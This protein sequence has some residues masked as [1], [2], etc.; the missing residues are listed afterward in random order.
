[1]S[2]SSDLNVLNVPQ[3]QYISLTCLSSSVSF[4]RVQPLDLTCVQSCVSRLWTMWG[5]GK[6]DWNVWRNQ[7][8]VCR[9]LCQSVLKVGVYL[10]LAFRCDDCIYSAL[11]ANV[12]RCSVITCPETCLSNVANIIRKSIENILRYDCQIDYY[13]GWAGLISNLLFNCGN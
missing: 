2:Y 7:T 6:H 13:Y 11:G 10:H 5:R 8:F 12:I 3:I 9:F 4:I 1:M